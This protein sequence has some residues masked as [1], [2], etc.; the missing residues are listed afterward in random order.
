[1]LWSSALWLKII[2]KYIL[3]ECH[4][5]YGS[6]FWTRIMACSLQLQWV[7]YMLK[8]WRRLTDVKY[9][10]LLLKKRMFI[11]VVVIDV[12]CAVLNNGLTLKCP[13]Y[14]IC[15]TLPCGSLR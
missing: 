15:L 4:H 8:W 3:E 5:L 1:M 12:H 2:S 6:L 13:T 11:V 10:Y 14:H 9:S 7:I